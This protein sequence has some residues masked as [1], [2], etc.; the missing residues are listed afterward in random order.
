MIKINKAIDEVVSGLER[1][2]YVTQ[3]DSTVKLTDKGER[4]VNF[5]LNKYPDLAILIFLSMPDS[6]R[7]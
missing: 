5:Y 6:G 4:F 1:K 7:Y 3:S 2:G